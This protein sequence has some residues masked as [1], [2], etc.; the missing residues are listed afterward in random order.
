MRG[1][2][3]LSPLAYE[4]L[5]R[6]LYG[7]EFACRYQAVARAV[8]GCASVVDVC[9][10]PALFARW[11]E[12]GVDYCGLDCNPSFARAAERRGV[13][14]LLGDVRAMEI[15]PADAVVIISG[16]YQFIPAQDEL[17]GRMIDACRK[18]T[19]VCEPI[20]HASQSNLLLS[21]LADVLLDPGVPY[22]HE[23][24]DEASLTACFHRLGFHHTERVGSRELMGVYEKGGAAARR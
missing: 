17:I 15:P 3:Y 9:C 23:R 20:K 4:G 22:S 13:R 21:R 18:R 1:L 7:R 6:L 2:F 10:G 16:L 24:F 11:L 8:E 14:V 12:K 5:M 19:V